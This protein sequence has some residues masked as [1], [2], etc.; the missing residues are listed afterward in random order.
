MPFIFLEYLL[1]PELPV[2]FRTE[3]VRAGIPVL[4]L[5]LEGKHWSPKDDISQEYVN[6][7]SRPQPGLVKK[8]RK[9]PVWPAAGLE[10]G[11]PQG[12]HLAGYFLGPM[13]GLGLFPKGREKLSG[14]LVEGVVS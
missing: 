13:Q 3:V 11:S 5:I 2:R 6:K 12:P 7:V 9:I 4:F 10:A 14:F 8:G 1:W